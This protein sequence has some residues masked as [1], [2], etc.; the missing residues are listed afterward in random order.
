[1]NNALNPNTRNDRIRQR[2]TM[3]H[4]RR[5][6]AVLGMTLALLSIAPLFF[7]TSRAQEPA[8]GQWTAEWQSESNEVKMTLHRRREGFGNNMSSVNFTPDKLQGLTKTQA[9]S[10]GTQVSFRL[11]RDAGTFACAGYFKDGKGAGHWTFTPD[12]N[13]I[14]EMRRLG[15]DDLTE[16]RLLA[17]AIHDVNLRFIQELKDAGYD[18]PAIDQL[19]AARIF[20]VTAEFVEEVRVLG[21]ERQSLEKLVAMRIHGVTP[22]FIRSVQ[23]SDFGRQSIDKLISMRIFKV[24]PEFAVEM[25]PLLPERPDV[26]QL[27]AMRIHG[28]TPDFIRRM[29]ERGLKDLSVDQLIKLRIHNIAK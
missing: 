28:V 24:T 4:R 19:I 5:G 22:A 23:A 27:T 17:C 12:Q 6:F 8:I 29:K 14:S 26:D 15:Y 7:A 11:T 13:F 25:R 18:R 21:Y 10:A 2:Q 16:E 20:N 9:F 1:M 3:S